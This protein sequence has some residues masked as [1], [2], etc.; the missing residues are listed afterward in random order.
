MTV[1]E[2]LEAEFACDHVLC[3]VR[4]L[5]A[6]NGVAQYVRQCLRCG[7]HRGAVAKASLSAS[8]RILLKP[9]DAE[10]R[11]TWQQ[12]RSACWN[13]AIAARRDEQLAAAE[14]RERQ[15]WDW[16]SEYLRSDVWRRRARAVLQ[17]D[18]WRCQAGLPGCRGDAEQAH[19]LTYKRV[20]QEPL[21]DLVAV[22]VPCHEQI[23]ARDREQRGS[24]SPTVS[25]VSW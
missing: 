23:T 7:A 11:R 13:E 8:Q 24:N 15:W 1:F 14:E 5:V 20:G 19:H 12:R 6:A 3:E 21:Y 10:L 25:E 17:R 22:C 4:V 18:G 2:T 16:Y 9:F